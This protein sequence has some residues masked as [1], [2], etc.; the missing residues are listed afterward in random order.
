MPKSSCISSGEESA[1]I[2]DPSD[3]TK[4]LFLSPSKSPNKPSV[5]PA[6]TVTCLTK[7]INLSDQDMTNVLWEDIKIS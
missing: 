3:P 7:Q 1:L 5:W 6:I 2:I 4:S